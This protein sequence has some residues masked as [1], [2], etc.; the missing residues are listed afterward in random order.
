MHIDKKLPQ[1]EIRCEQPYR[2]LLR[3]ALKGDSGVRVRIPEFTSA[4]RM[5][6]RVNG[7]ELPGTPPSFGNY[8][9]LGQLHAGDRIEMAYP[10]PT[11]TEDIV[12]GNPG[13]RQWRY[14]ATWKG[15]TVVRMEPVD[16]DVETAY[17]DFDKSQVG[18]FYGRSGPGNLYQ[19]DQM[20]QDVGPSE[21]ELQQDDG[22]L[23]FWKIT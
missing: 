2:G 15:D 13:F 4:A 10:L 1:A 9:E 16:N 18:V 6:V 23:D 12:I 19:R 17:S 14:R 7:A 21:A 3:I 11:R 5:T 22:G 20:L 8:L